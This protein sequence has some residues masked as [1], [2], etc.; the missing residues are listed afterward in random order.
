MPDVGIVGASAALLAVG[1]VGR[2]AVGHLGAAG[3]R[4]RSAVPLRADEARG[5]RAR[6]LVI[7]ELCAG[8]V[9]PLWAQLRAAVELAA[10]RQF[11]QRDVGARRVLAEVARPYERQAAAAKQGRLWVPPRR[12]AG[13]EGVGVVEEVVGA[14]VSA[15]VDG[16]AAEARRVVDE[17]ALLGAHRR[18]V[19][20]EPAAVVR[21]VIEERHLDHPQRV[22]PV[23]DATTE[24]EVVLVGVGLG[25]AVATGDGEPDELAPHAPCDVQHA[26]RPHAVEDYLGVC[27]IVCAVVCAIVCVRQLPTPTTALCFRRRRRRLW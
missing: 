26:C 2:A 22:A 7:G 4:R 15:D 6:A 8:A 25:M 20:V 17:V 10:F 19:R 21:L 11:A 16:V 5:A 23:L 9:E 13:L 1:H 27:A 18:A 12:H 3:A 24:A 14:L